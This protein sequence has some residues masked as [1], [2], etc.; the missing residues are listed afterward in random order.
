MPLLFLYYVVLPIL[1]G[2]WVI[3]WLK[4]HAPSTTPPALAELCARSPIE[5][6]W[7]R[8]VRVAAGRFET[9]GDFEK[10]EQAVE[11]AYRGRE[12]QPGSGA[13]FL[14]VNDKAEV[15]EQVDA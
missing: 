12:R 4:R 13:S 5:K 1:F 14:V 8:V 2:W 10:Q 11:E 3:R 15:L 6:R 9:V 7:F